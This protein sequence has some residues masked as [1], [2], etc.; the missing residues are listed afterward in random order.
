MLILREVW[1]KL[2]WKSEGMGETV[3][4]TFPALPFTVVRS[5]A[6]SFKPFA[7]LRWE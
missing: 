6:K 1:E 2:S 5:Q 3:P 4:S 7:S